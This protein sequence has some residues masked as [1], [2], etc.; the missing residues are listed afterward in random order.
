MLARDDLDLYAYVGN[1][2]LDHADPSGLETGPAFREEV[3]TSYT[4]GAEFM[5]GDED[6]ISFIADSL[7]TIGGHPASKLGP[8]GKPKVHTR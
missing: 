2:P 3:T 1:N 8:S 7:P 6:P 5:P 4:P